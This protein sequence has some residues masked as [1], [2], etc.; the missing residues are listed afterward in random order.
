MDEFN[1]ESGYISDPENDD[2]PVIP[3][4]YSKEHYVNTLKSLNKQKLSFSELV[5]SI[6]SL[7]G[8]LNPNIEEYSYIQDRASGNYISEYELDSI[9]EVLLT[10]EGLDLAYKTAMVP[11]YMD[12]LLFEY[13]ISDGNG[14]ITLVE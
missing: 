13:N 12:K 8:T 10:L 7:H 9:L 2:M 1:I 14:Y 11:C 3:V 5:S 6:I 4:I